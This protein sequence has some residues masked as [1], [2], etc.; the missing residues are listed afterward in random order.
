MIT[1][2]NGESITGAPGYVIEMAFPL[3]YLP[4]IFPVEPGSRFGLGMA[5]DDNDGQGRKSQIAWPAGWRWNKPETWGV[6]EF[7]GE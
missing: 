1:A 4:M 6:G 7:V 5:L 3:D 2:K